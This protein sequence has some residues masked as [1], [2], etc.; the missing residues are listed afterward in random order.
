MGWR[1]REDLGLRRDNTGRVLWCRDNRANTL[2]LRLLAARCVGSV[3]GGD[4]WS[5][6]MCPLE[7]CRQLYR[8]GRWTGVRGRAAGISGPSLPQGS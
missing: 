5:M 7:N 6:A 4:K 3:G 2:P 8:E 1:G